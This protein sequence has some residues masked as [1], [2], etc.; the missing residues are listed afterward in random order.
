MNVTKHC[1]NTPGQRHQQPGPQRLERLLFSSIPVDDGTCTDNRGGGL[2]AGATQTPNCGGPRDTL[3]S[4]IW[5]V[6]STNP[7]LGAMV[8]LQD[9]SSPNPTN[10]S[11]LHSHSASAS[12]LVNDPTMVVMAAE[13]CTYEDDPFEGSP[14][15]HQFKVPARP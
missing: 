5:F 3:R 4:L 6:L 7:N 13:M 11:D 2:A 9:W 10:Y 14:T 8:D 12:V 1:R 15:N